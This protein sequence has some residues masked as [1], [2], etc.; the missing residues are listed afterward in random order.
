MLFEAPEPVEQTGPGKTAHVDRDK[1]ASGAFKRR[2]I[3]EKP[4]LIYTLIHHLRLI[5]PSDSEATHGESSWMQEVLRLY[6]Q[7]STRINH[8]IL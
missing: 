3:E 7:K 5:S 4:K 8:H 6:L 1:I 2:K